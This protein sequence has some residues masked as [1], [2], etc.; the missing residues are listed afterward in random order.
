MIQ[1]NEQTPRG[2]KAN[3]LPTKDITAWLGLLILGTLLMLV[4]AN[5]ARATEPLVNA[6]W[7]IDNL[8]KPGIRFVDLQSPEGFSRAHLPGAVN[9]P[10]SRWR[11]MKPGQ[12]SMMRSVEH[13]ERHLG[14]LGIEKGTH[15]I[16]MP[17]AVNVSELAVATRVYWTLRVLGHGKISILDGGLIGLSQRKDAS[18]TT[19]TPPIAPTIYKAQPDMTMV[20]D[21]EDVLLDLNKGVRFVD[22]RSE[23]EYFGENGSSGTIPGSIHL[24]YADF[25]DAKPGG[26][27]LAIDKIKAIYKAKGIIPEGPEIAF[28]N[29]A[30]RASLSWFVQSEL[31]G[32]RQVRL[33]DGSINEWSSNPKYPL[34][35]PAR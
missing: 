18:F 19:I 22:Y 25:M 34:I 23:G 14:E 30:H 3:A 15:V 26:K 12:G 10:Y 8:G 21:A 32:N 7:V 17:L 11:V 5:H 28:C 33:Y 9:S 1:T 20:P 24:H 29:S 31:L 13:L 16:L 35:I 27:F 4:A 6:Q 2:T